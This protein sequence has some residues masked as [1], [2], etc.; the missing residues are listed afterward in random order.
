MPSLDPREWRNG[1]DFDLAENDGED[2]NGRS[3]FDMDEDEQDEL[4]E[5]AMWVMA[6]VLQRVVINSCMNATIYIRPK[7]ASNGA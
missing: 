5:D 3:F 7:D 6:G 2:Y 4:I 1:I